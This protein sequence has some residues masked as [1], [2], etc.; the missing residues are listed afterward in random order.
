MISNV[1]GNGGVGFS[2]TLTTGVPKEQENKELEALQNQAAKLAEILSGSKDSVEISDEARALS[3]AMREITEGS[4][5]EQESRAVRTGAVDTREN[6]T[7]TA[8]DYNK[9]LK[10]L[11]AEYGEEEA[12]RRFDKI[13]KEDGYELVTDPNNSSFSRASSLN[14]AFRFAGSFW[15][16]DGD[17]PPL[18][19]GKGLSQSN[20]QTQSTLKA[21]IID[22]EVRYLAETHANYAAHFGQDVYDALNGLYQKNLESAQSKVS[23]DLGG[24]MKDHFGNN[25]QTS[26]VS[27]STELGTVAANL[28]KAAGVELGA[29]DTVSFTLKA[30]G[31]GLNISGTFE[32]NEAVQAAVDA[33]LKKNP[34]MLQAF[35]DEYNSVAMTDVSALDGAYND[36]MRSVSYDDAFRSFIY[37]ARE[38][39]AVVMTDTVGVYSTGY[40]YQKKVSDSFDANADVTRVVGAG[41]SLSDSNYDHQRVNRELEERVSRAMETGEQIESTMTKA[42]SDAA[43]EARGGVFQTGTGVLS[44]GDFDPNAKLHTSGG[45][46]EQETRAAEAKQAL[47]DL[48]ADPDIRD[49]E[50]SAEISD[51]A[52]DLANGSELAKLN[53]SQNAEQKKYGSSQARQDEGARLDAYLNELRQKYGENE[54]MSRFNEY[55]RSEGYEVYENV[56]SS[57]RPEM[58]V[59][60]LGSN[61]FERAY[62]TLGTNP[63]TL[64]MHL[65]LADVGQSGGSGISTGGYTATSTNIHSSFKLQSS[66]AGSVRDGNIEYDSS[67][68]AVYDAGFSSGDSSEFAEWSKRNAAALSEKA[69]F[70]VGEYLD[71]FTSNTPIWG[72]AFAAESVS[73]DLAGILSSI[74]KDSGIQLAADENMSFIARES[75][76]GGVTGLDVNMNFGDAVLR[77]KIQTAIDSAFMK[78]PAIAKAFTTEN[79]SVAQADLD[80]LSYDNGAQSRQFAQQRMFLFSG[81]NTSAVVMGSGLDS[82]Q[83][84]YV[85]V[86]KIADSVDLTADTIRITSRTDSGKAMEQAART[87][88]LAEEIKKSQATA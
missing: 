45:N 16:G 84:G 14:P 63:L 39:S 37:S 12:M 46:A 61:T 80:S 60:G 43:R 26:A 11:R 40:N 76:D 28:L 4:N 15:M 59:T 29:D 69:G 71:K 20:L 44:M 73:T 67:T 82:K 38:P 65:S 48:E 51:I 23:F 66:V 2:G 36:G 88:Q 9:I 55:M 22:G 77:E 18:L 41:Y 10:D 72:K 83:S 47:Q 34:D 13:M 81:D 85:Y 42:E 56:S 62:G 78:D 32:D 52:K 8:K 79:R 75:E 30:D 33:A 68:W 3:E 35:K 27:A 70:D 58:G 64:G 17:I 87:N 6:R 19:V 21:D 57:T 53:T 86:K 24:Y 7:E 50:N 1:A 74:L 49:R 54:A 31:S 5:A 25:P